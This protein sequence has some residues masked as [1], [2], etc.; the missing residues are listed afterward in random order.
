MLKEPKVL[1][2]DGERLGHNF[3]FSLKLYTFFAERR[4]KINVAK[5]MSYKCDNNGMYVDIISN[6]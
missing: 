1:K 5:S 3:K 2:W 4:E 6:R